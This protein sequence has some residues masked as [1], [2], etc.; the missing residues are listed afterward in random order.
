VF[1]VEQKGI[2]AKFVWPDAR[3]DANQQELLAGPHP[4][5]NHQD[6]QTGEGV[7]E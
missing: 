4:F 1:D 7:S 5:S 6:F 2:G 3:H